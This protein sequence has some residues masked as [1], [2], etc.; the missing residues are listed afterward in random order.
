M[1]NQVDKNLLELK[2]NETGKRYLRKFFL[3]GPAIFIL[4]IIITLVYIGVEVDGIRKSDW[5]HKL[6]SVKDVYYFIYP[7][8]A[9]C[10]SALACVGVVYYVQFAR[11]IRESL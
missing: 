11:K 3:L 1:D 10:Y 2:V 8:F 5:S 4:N 6:V 9:I 7:L